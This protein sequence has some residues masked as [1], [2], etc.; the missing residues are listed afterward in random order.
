MR[1]TSHQRP[2]AINMADKKTSQFLPSLYQMCN[3]DD[4]THREVP[5]PLPLFPPGG[6]PIHPNPSFYLRK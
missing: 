1:E 6:G 3:K 2:S 4:Q 5:H